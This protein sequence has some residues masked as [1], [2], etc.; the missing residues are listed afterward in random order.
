MLLCWFHGK[1]TL[2]ARLVSGGFR[3][4]SFFR[5]SL[6]GSSGWLAVGLGLV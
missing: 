3:L 1:E 6:T 4:H 5:V 2:G